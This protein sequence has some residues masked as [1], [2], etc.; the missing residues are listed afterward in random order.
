[1]KNKPNSLC[2]IREV[3]GSDHDFSLCNNMY[4]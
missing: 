1:M 3:T 4:C 2:Y